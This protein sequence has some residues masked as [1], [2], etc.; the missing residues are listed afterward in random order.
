MNKRSRRKVLVIGVLFGVTVA[1][2]LGL[3]AFQENLLYFYSPTQVIA[4]EAPE[5]HSFRIGGLVVDGTVNRKPDSLDV[6]FD[7]TDNTETVTVQYTGILP[8]LFREGQGIVAMG[9]LQ[10]GGLFIAE[11]VLAKHDEN[12]MPPEVADALKA[13]E[14]AAKQ[15]MQ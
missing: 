4:G 15:K 11:E 7:L 8:D 2:V 14:E 9:S 1:A 10:P 12:Y 6:Q 5:N 13:S 3:T